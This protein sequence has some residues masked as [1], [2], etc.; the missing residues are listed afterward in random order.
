MF[1]LFATK[2]AKMSALHQGKFSIGLYQPIF[3][4]TPLKAFIILVKGNFF[5]YHMKA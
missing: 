4:R 3:D 1:L 2:G 5:L